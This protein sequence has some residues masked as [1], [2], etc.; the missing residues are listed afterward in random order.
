MDVVSSFSWPRQRR[1]PPAPGLGQ[2][3]GDEAKKRTLAG[4]FLPQRN[5]SYLVRATGLFPLDLDGVEN[6]QEVRQRVC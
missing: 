4:L 6:N 1:L 5:K 3:Q 2:G